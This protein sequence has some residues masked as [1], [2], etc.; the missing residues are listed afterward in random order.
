MGLIYNDGNPVQ[1]L[2][3][4]AA[5]QHFTLL[6][7]HNINKLTHWWSRLLSL[8]YYKILCYVLFLS[9]VSYK[10]ST[11]CASG[12]K[13]DV[14]TDLLKT[15]CLGG[16]AFWHMGFKVS[17]SPEGRELC[18]L[19]EAEKQKLRGFAGFGMGYACS[20]WAL[21]KWASSWR[22]YSCMYEHSRFYAGFYYCTVL[23]HGRLGVL[24]ALGWVGLKASKTDIWDFN[25]KSLLF[26]TRPEVPS[27]YLESLIF[28]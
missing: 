24:S 16:R 7:I 22:L 25:N 9:W 11:H 8:L 27:C 10:Q 12:T 19:L 26:K 2:D 4:P 20:K 17:L 18:R 5:V 23:C 6:P 3:I 28:S 14:S 21:G 13:Q 15:S 1:L